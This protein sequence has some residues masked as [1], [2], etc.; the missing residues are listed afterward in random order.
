M[1]TKAIV[2]RRR[3][4]CIFVTVMW[5]EWHVGMFL[6]AN[7]PTMLADGNLPAFAETI[8]F[9]YLIYTT[10]ADAARMREHP[11]FLR[12]QASTE[13][14]LELFT[15]DAASNPIGLHH[16][17]WA[18]AITHARERDSFILLMPPDVVWANGSFRRL[19]DVL[20]TGKHA[21]FMT[22]PRVVS[23]TLVPSMLERFPRGRDQSLDVPPE[24]MMSLALTHI[25][26]LMAAYI[27]SAS[28]FPIHP[29]MVLFPVKG[30]GFLLR[31]LAR[32]LFCFEPGRY[33][34]NA[35]ALLARFPPLD[36]IHVF[37]NSREFLGLS[38]T[39]LWKDME[40]YLSPNR[41]DPL[42][43][44]RWW[45]TYD[46]PFNDYL[47]GRNL[48]FTTGSADEAS[49]RRVEREADIAVTH[50][51]L[52][53]EFI[54]ILLVMQDAGCMRAA[55]F[56]AAALR[57]HG[58]ERRWPFRGPFLVLAPRDGAFQDRAG[59]LFP[60][61]ETDVSEVIALLKAHVAPLPEGRALME[62][63]EVT[64]LAGRSTRLTDVES[65][66]MSGDNMVL[67]VETF[68]HDDIMI[69]GR[70]MDA[71]VM[72]KIPAGPAERPAQD[73]TR[74]RPE[75]SHGLPKDEVQEMARHEPD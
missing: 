45:I 5:G 65:A 11:A 68:L 13:I 35:Q 67:P 16:E 26:P 47:S 25:H 51:K 49:W 42:S 46:S 59:M 62:G 60:G 10:P 9:E 40:W 20:A 63:E 53:R 8:E 18:K 24:D 38:L 27:R 70:D 43:V 15:P 23:E 39:P 30:D 19:G 73:E 21:I 36:E 17:I 52:A 4:R 22:Y 29:E 50:F 56:L 48:R 37:D 69:S 32:E 3:A 33:E 1:T 12:L 72:P 34:L 55:G 71:A 75:R 7:L 14:R 64:T 44:G 2:N 31:L 61:A 41:L 74:I 58:V 66:R 28:H 6:D 54:R 57:V